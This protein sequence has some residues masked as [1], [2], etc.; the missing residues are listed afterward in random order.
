QGF[1]LTF[2]CAD[3]VGVVVGG[4]HADQ[5]GPEHNKADC[6]QRGIPGGVSILPAGEVGE[7]SVHLAHLLRHLLTVVAVESGFA[8]MA[9]VD[10]FGAGRAACEHEGGKGCRCNLLHCH[11]PILWSLIQSKSELPALAV[12]TPVRLTCCGACRVRQGLPTAS[13]AIATSSCW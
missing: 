7:A 11:L 10:A 9:G 4:C 8:H 5:G 3:L 6:H 12:C 1:P 2:Q 13:R